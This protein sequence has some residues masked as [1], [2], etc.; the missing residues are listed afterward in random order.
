VRIACIF[1]TAPGTGGLGVQADNVLTSLAEVPGA[2]VLALGPAPHESARSASLPQIRWVAP[3]R[4]WFDLARSVPLARSRTGVLALK[5][6]EYLGR[7]A[8]AHLA[9]EPPELCYAFTQV[10]VEAFEWC[11]TRR[12][13]AIL[14]SPNGHIDNF[15]HVYV[16]EH[17]AWCGG[18]YRGHPTEA[19][20]ARVR[21]EYDLASRIRVS[22]GWTLNSLASA[23]VPA[24]RIV[25]IEQ[26]VDLSRY[27][28]AKV[29]RS[30]AGP[31]RV[32]FVG[33]LDL[34]KGFVYL[35]DAFARLDPTAFWLEI[36]GATGDRCS[37]RLLDERW[38]PNATCAPGDPRP[39]YARA[40]L[41]V[42]P[43]LED[44]SPFAVA[45]AMASGIPVIVTTNCGAAEWVRP[46]TGWVVPPRDT[47]ALRRALQEAFER[48]ADLPRMGR[49]ARAD[50]EA[51][52]GEHCYR[53]LADWVEAIFVLRFTM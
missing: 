14:E 6:A 22:S 42:L 26:R 41:F 9:K 47:Q 31:L 1:S 3:P 17:A 36:V 5:H 35:L 33:S 44:G 38:P 13:P 16:E 20:A 12:V 32:C 4:W 45:E 48:R 27:H 2:T 7:W 46:E 23:G 34:R 28:P 11:A 43:T 15:R 40:D 30:Q 10:A 50:T 19:M 52:A 8:A 49:E 37:R 53:A 29:P 21:R 51:R 39:A 18:R 25:K 24:E